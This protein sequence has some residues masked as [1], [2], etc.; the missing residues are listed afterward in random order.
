MPKNPRCQYTGQVSLPPSAVC[1][2]RSTGLKA[3]QHVMRVTCRVRQWLSG[4]HL[5]EVGKGKMKKE[6]LQVSESLGLK[7]MR[8]AGVITLYW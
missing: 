5:P 2:K 6:D 4:V 1:G 3:R 7:W 8:I